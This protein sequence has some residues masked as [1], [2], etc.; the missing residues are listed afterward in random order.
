MPLQAK[1]M[2]SLCLFIDLYFTLV[3]VVNEL[4]FKRKKV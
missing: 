1:F 2:Y 3:N 4:K